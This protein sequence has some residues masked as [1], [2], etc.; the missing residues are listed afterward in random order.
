[1]TRPGRVTRAVA[2]RPAGPDGHVPTPLVVAAAWTWRLAV[3]AV[4]LAGA[5]WL[6]SVFQ[7]IVVPVLVAVL[8]TAL[9]APLVDWLQRHRVPRGLGVL[10][11]VLGSLALLS[12][13]LTGVGA[14][15]VA[16]L[17][18]LAAQVTTGVD[19]VRAWLAQGPLGIG[20]AQLDTYLDQAR[21]QVRG[22]GQQLV[23]G[24][25]QFTS[26]A[27]H[28]VTGFF[29]TVFA[30]IFLLLDGRGIAAWFNG[31]LPGAAREPVALAAER[32]WA[33]LTSFVR[34]T[35]VVAFVDAVGIGVGA[36]L[37]S[38]PL[39]LPLGVLVFLGAFVPIVGALLTGAVAVLVALVAQGPGVALAMLAVVIGV[40]QAESHLLQP[41]LLGR[42]VAVHPLA[43][44]LAIA[45]GVLV[46]GVVGGLFAVPLVAVVNTMA[47]SLAGRH[48]D[49]FD[50]ESDDADADADGG[51]AAAGGA[52]AASLEHTAARDDQVAYVANTDQVVRDRP[53]AG[54]PGDST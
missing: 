10:L 15:V 4:G 23:A 51:V 36:A 35:V 27:G 22:N 32:G 37:L 49:D 1:M 47:L 30:L 11:V 40:Q 7:V 29:L 24:A 44:I 5:L 46:A 52:D 8:A 17:G 28:V 25:L 45:A 38:V 41:L 6:V 42:A 39:A 33:T 20:S 14:A 18:D 50:H 13:L 26:T 3:V 19:Q 12:G 21:E 16:G 2:Q 9:L 48:R 34:A 54:G 31:L 43:V 53:A